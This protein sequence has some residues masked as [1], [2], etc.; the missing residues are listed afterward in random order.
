[1][2]VRTRRRLADMKVVQQQAVELFT[3]HGFDAV[4]VER[5][6]TAAG[7]SPV[8]VYRWFGTKEAL[9]LWDDY[10]PPLLAAIARHLGDRGPLGAVRD[11]VVEELDVVYDRDRELVLAR[12]RLIHAEPALRAAA[13][14]GTTAME[15]ALAGL[16]ADAGMGD[17]DARRRVWAVV[18]V[19]VL[20]AAL[21]TWQ[22]QDGRESLADVV[23]AAF[24]SLEVVA[25][26]A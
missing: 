16:Y 10:D 17:D 18:A 8:S 6:A 15:E 24:A 20:R 9:V 13:T 23:T 19:G 4:P 21:D 14:H 12:T 3:T 22:R 5:V 2:D 11:G 25:W 1:M 26:T 7:V